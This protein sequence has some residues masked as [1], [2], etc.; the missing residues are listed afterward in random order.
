MVNIELDCFVYRDSL[1]LFEELN[2][3]W[4]RKW[5]RELHLTETR[6][7]LLCLT[8]ID[9]CHLKLRFGMTEECQGQFNMD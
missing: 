8:N 1:Y 5:T 4:I 3:K 9:Q 6:M 2:G 7:S